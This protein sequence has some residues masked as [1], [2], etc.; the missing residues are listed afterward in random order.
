MYNGIIDITTQNPFNSILQHMDK[1]YS[2]QEL[3]FI[4]MHYKSSN[5]S[6]LVQNKFN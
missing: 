4:M 1:S 5:H 6:N 2:K 3:L